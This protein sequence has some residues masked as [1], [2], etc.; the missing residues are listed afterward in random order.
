MRYHKTFETPSL[1]LSFDFM[2][3]IN[4]STVLDDVFKLK[5]TPTS[6]LRTL[7]STGVKDNFFTNSIEWISNNILVV[8]IQDKLYA[9]NYA[10]R[11][12][13][14]LG[15]LK[16]NDEDFIHQT[17]FTTVARQNSKRIS[18]ELNKE[19]NTRFAYGLSDGRVRFRDLNK[20]NKESGF[21]QVKRKN[22][23]NAMC[24]KEN[25][26]AAGYENGELMFFDLRCGLISTSEHHKK[27][28]CTLKFDLYGQYLAC[29]SADSTVSIWC[30]M[31]EAPRQILTESKS[32]VKG[33]AWCG[34]RRNHLFTGSTTPEDK[35]RLYSLN[36]S[37]E[38]KLKKEV[39]VSS[40]VSSLIYSKKHKSLISTH[41]IVD[42]FTINLEV[43]DVNNTNSIKC[44]EP[45]NLDFQGVIGSHS[46]KILSSVYN[47]EEN[48]FVSLSS[49]ENMK[50]WNL[51]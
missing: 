16:D 39:V 33:L 29:A 5:Y 47:E 32:V 36:F 6:P 12:V 21:F 27:N 10:K 46:R 38:E 2:S 41:G 1:E 14:L 7:D 19:T 9:Y 11:V 50:F 49:D 22:A 28:I 45:S 26:I 17:K 8:C 13:S 20:I 30:A 37:E 34:E 4:Y 40:G 25:V 42:D 31:D 3:D 51:L 24:W 15:S 43:L 35:I 18:G 48:L 44:W 23:V